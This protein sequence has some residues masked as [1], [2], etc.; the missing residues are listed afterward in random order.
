MRDLSEQALIE[1]AR[2]GGEEA[3]EALIH[4]Y[5]KRVF[6][7]TRRL[8][9]NPEDAAEAAQDAFLAV[10]RGLP[11]YRGEAGFSTWLYRLTVNACMDLL[12]REGRRAGASGPSIDDEALNLELPAPGPSPQEEAERAELR[13]AVEAGL[14]TLPEEY[15]AALIL[16]EL[17][18][19]SYEEIAQSLD[20]DLGTVKS[21]ISRGRKLLRKYLLQ[22]GNFSPPGPSKETEANETGKGAA[23]EIL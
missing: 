23:N 7:L 5:E 9:P 10:W 6:A 22:T 4:L 14:R 20:A 8:C 17:H 18:Q 11:A 15:R 12:R 16:R 2:T 19:L 21:R 13:E 3:F 1:A